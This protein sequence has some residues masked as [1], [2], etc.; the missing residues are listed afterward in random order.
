MMVGAAVQFVNST[1]FRYDLV[2]LTRQV[3]QE[4]SWNLYDQIIEAYNQKNVSGVRSVGL[5]S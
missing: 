3:L 2:D 4:I 1:T 5:L